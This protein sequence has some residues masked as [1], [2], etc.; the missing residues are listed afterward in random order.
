MHAGLEFTGISGPQGQQ[1]GHARN[2]VQGHAVDGGVAPVVVM[3]ALL[4]EQA[5]LLIGLRGLRGIGQHGL[6]NGIVAG[7]QVGFAHR[8]KVHRT[9]HHSLREAGRGGIDVVLRGLEVESR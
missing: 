5:L 2:F 7:E 4:G 3:A 1:S 8:V 6:Q 9:A